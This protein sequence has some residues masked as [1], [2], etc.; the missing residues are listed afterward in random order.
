M[1]LITMSSGQKFIDMNNDNHNSEIQNLRE[2]DQKL[3]K[4]QMPEE[5]TGKVVHGYGRGM[6]A[7][8]SHKSDISLFVRVLQRHWQL[9]LACMLSVFTAVA[10][11]TFLMKSVYEPEAHLEVDAPGNELFALDMP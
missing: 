4:A 10:V 11:A 2:N 1:R 3:A 6:H 8:G 7:A 5:V 9:S